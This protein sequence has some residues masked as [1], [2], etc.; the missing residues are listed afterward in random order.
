MI[1][2]D[3][4]N[5]SL[6]IAPVSQAEGN[7]GNTMSFTGSLEPAWVPTGY[8]PVAVHAR[9]CRWIGYHGQATTSR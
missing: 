8:G 7:A 9:H 3:D 5:L 6:S 1:N 4:V 2:N